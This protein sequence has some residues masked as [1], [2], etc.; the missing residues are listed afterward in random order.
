MWRKRT[1]RSLYDLHQDRS[2]SVARCGCSPATDITVKSKFMSAMFVFV[3][4]SVTGATA[5]APKYE[6][7]G[8]CCLCMCHALDENKCAPVCVRMQHGWKKIIEEPEM[9]SC[10]KS[11]LRHGVK[12]IFPE[13]FDTMDTPKSSRALITPVHLPPD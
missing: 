7:G 11:C 6:P 12:Q 1:R 8:W 4:L 3:V 5:R 9:K 10:T 13:Q 2:L